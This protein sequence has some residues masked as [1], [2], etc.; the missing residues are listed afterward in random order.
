MKNVK[1]IFAA[2][3]VCVALFSCATS[4]DVYKS[5]D[6]AVFAVKYDTA[7]AGIER[8][9]AIPKGKKKPAKPIY[10]AGDEI[11]LYLDKGILE[12]YAGKHADSAQDLEEAARLIQEAYTKSLSQA[13]ASFI[14]NDNTKD[15]AGEDYEDLYTNVIDALNYYHTG[16]TDNALVAIRGLNVKIQALNVK[17]ADDAKKGIGALRESVENGPAPVKAIFLPLIDQLQIPAPATVNFSDSALGEY[18]GGILAKNSFDQNERANADSYFKALDA[19][20][21][22][23]PAIY[24]NKPAP[25]YDGDG[26]LIP[27]S[28][29]DQELNVPEGKARLNIVAFTGLAPELVQVDTEVPIVITK[30]MV[31]MTLSLPQLRDRT[32]GEP[33]ASMSVTVNGQSVELP[34]IENIGAVINETY[35]AKASSIWTKTFIRTLVKYMVA[36]QA[37]QAAVDKGT[38]PGLAFVV[39]K[40]LL[41]ASEQADTRSSRYLPEAAY[42][43]GVT[44]DPGDYT[45]NFGGKAVD[46]KVEAGKLNLVELVS[47]R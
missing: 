1:N 26:K 13:G 5:V 10:P 46:V 23:A 8:A 38:P 4:K 42:V 24:A 33:G 16:D 31:L 20:V 27:G 6:N 7:L 14:A 30:V 21:A 2:A 12:H 19:A 44:L 32:P 29:A 17:Y 3:A 41:G 34:L 11:L 28:L 36:D 35:K 9:Q 39:G 40:K 47:L 25:S 37:A 15:Y 43:G 18:L 22:D 45:I